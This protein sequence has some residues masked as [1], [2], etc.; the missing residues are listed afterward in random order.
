MVSSYTNT[1]FL[2]FRVIIVIVIIVVSKIYLFAIRYGV[3]D[4]RI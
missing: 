2:I 4:S 1:F 3:E